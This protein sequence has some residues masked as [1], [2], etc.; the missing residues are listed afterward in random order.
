MFQFAFPIL[1]PLF[2]QSLALFFFFGV[3]IAISRCQVNFNILQSHFL[4]VFIMASKPAIELESESEA[5]ATADQSSPSQDRPVSPVQRGWQLVIAVLLLLQI[6]TIAWLLAGKNPA[7]RQMTIDAA[8]E[9][10]T[11][12]RKM[13]ADA[14]LKGDT[15]QAIN[16]YEKLAAESKHPEDQQRLAKLYAAVLNSRKQQGTTESNLLLSAQN[17]PA[18][19]AAAEKSY[20]QEQYAQAQH[21]FYRFLLQADQAA[22]SREIVTIAYFRIQQCLVFQSLPHQGNGDP[23]LAQAWE[24]MKK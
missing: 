9:L 2:H 5:V 3:F 12:W 7:P 18:L 11:Q 4:G 13:A 19:F 17:L 1:S 24:L 10:I 22:S 20:N 23:T 8:P 15:E 14:E 6:F 16:F 21:L